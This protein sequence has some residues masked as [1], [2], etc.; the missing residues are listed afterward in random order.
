MRIPPRNHCLFRL[1]QQRL[2][3]LDRSEPKPHV[4]TWNCLKEGKHFRLPPAVC[5]LPTQC[6]VVLCSVYEIVQKIV[7]YRVQIICNEGFYWLYLKLNHVQR[8][9]GHLPKDEWLQTDVKLKK[10]IFILHIFFLWWVKF[11]RKRSLFMAVDTAVSSQGPFTNYSRA[12]WSCREQTKNNCSDGCKFAIQ[13]QPSKSNSCT[14]IV[15]S[16]AQSL[17]CCHVSSST[18]TTKRGSDA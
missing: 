12:F 18:A 6:K 14:D 7:C 10:I 2:D 9:G 13:W 15:K 4:K 1:L 17:Q 8:T 5:F 16:S 3:C 11:E